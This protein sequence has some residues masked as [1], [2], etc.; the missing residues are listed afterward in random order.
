[1]RGWVWEKWV[2]FRTFYFMKNAAR[3]GAKDLFAVKI[4]QFAGKRDKNI[5]K[6]CNFK[7][8]IWNLIAIGKMG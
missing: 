1:M 8:F 6:V 7:I 4:L 5:E 2:L 3:P